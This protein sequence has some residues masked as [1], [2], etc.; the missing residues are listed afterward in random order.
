MRKS[1]D[2]NYVL[3]LGHT[4]TGNQR[5]SHITRD[6]SMFRCAQ[7]M[8]FHRSIVIFLL[9]A[10]SLYLRGAGNMMCDVRG[11]GVTGAI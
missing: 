4:I 11:F 9:L 6:I 7:S 3:T 5:D 1:R 10:R 8:R 2:T